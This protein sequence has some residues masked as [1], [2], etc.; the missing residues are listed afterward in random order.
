MKAALGSRCLSVSKN[1][2]TAPATVRKILFKLKFCE[3]IKREPNE[4]IYFF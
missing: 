4:P 1:T 2:D 3:V